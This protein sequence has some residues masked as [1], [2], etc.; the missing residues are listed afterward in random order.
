MS[1]IFVGIYF[2]LSRILHVVVY[3]IFSCFL[4]VRCGELWGVFLHNNLSHS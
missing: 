2:L 3:I 4:C 1:D